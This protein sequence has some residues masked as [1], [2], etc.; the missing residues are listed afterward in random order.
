MAIEISGNLSKNLVRMAEGH[1]M[2]SASDRM[3][4]GAGGLVRQRPV[5]GFR[6]Q[7]VVTSLPEVDRSRHCD[8]IEGPGFVEHRG[9]GDKPPAPCRK[10]SR[11][12][13]RKDWQTCSS[14]NTS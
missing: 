12:A 4:E 3:P 10:H 9:I 11:E 6:H 14:N 13:S 2:T 8:P 7:I 1:E 5:D